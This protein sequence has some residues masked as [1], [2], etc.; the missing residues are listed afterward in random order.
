[1]WTQFRE[2]FRRNL[3]GNVSTLVHSFFFFSSRRRHTRFKCDWSSDVC[4]SDLRLH[5]PCLLLLPRLTLC[6]MLSP[7]DQSHEQR[8]TC[9]DEQEAH[10][11]IMH[12]CHE[13]I[14]W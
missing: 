11:R 7:H 10:E 4:S 13:C 14:I 3:D 2:D 1:M 12:K 6:P 9:Q 8:L 5:F